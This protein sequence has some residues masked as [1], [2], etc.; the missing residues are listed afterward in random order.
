MS[1]EKTT[2]HSKKPLRVGFDFDGVIMYNPAR[3]IRPI[4]SFFKKR[5]LLFNRKELEFFIPK[6]KFEKMFFILLHQSSIFPAIGL[7]EIKKLVD[8]GEIEAYVITGRFSFLEPDFNRWLKKIEAK[9]IFKACYYNKNDEQP[10]LFKER[11]INELKL[12]LFIEDNWDIVNYLHRKF[13]TKAGNQKTRI[14]WIYNLF[15]RKITFKNKFTQL[16]EALNFLKQD[17]LKIDNPKILAVSD[18]FFPHWTG[19]SKSVFHLFT[20]LSHTFEI[21][22]LTVKHQSKLKKREMINGFWIQRARPVFQ[23]SRA[24]YAPSIIPRTWK[25]LLTADILFIN[26]PFTNILPV[27]LLSKLLGKKIIIFHQGDLRLPSGL[28]NRIIEFVFTSMTWWSF[29]LADRLSTYTLDYAEHSNVMKHFLYKVKPIILPIP[30][31]PQKRTK[32]KTTTPILGF[33]GRFVEEKGFDI[34]FQAIPEVLESYPDVRF[35]F[36]GQTK[37]QYEKFYEKHADE[38]KKVKK[39]IDFLGLLSDEELEKF[40]ASVDL[41][42]LPSRSECFGLVQAEAMLQGTPV[43]S[44]DI[45][46]SRM[47]VKK[48]KF[49][50]LFESENPNDLADMIVKALKNREEL[51]KHQQT[52]KEFLNYDTLVNKSAKLFEF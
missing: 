7:D 2:T 27:T 29:A 33:A 47:L 8:A 17:L 43:V 23:F 9:H 26:S 34:L 51:M 13:W 6:T 21:E 39:Y 45:P 4:V 40:Y 48:T 36:A 41:F 31:S 42:L 25:K 22:V 38:I 14:Y 28:M 46:G 37:M 18:Y 44:S 5:K 20:A 49:G 1:P 16:H 24:F 32:S 15:D 12:D 52:A 50:Y 11:M 3:V 30:S 35:A 19:L 10:H